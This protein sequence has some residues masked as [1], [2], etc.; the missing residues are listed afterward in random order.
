MYFQDIDLGDGYRILF[1]HTQEV[2]VVIPVEMKGKVCGLC[3]NFDGNKTND[4][5]LGYYASADGPKM[6][7]PAQVI[8]PGHPSMEGHF[9]D[10]V[11]TCICACLQK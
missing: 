6:T 10:D 1:D 11:G 5:Q 3:G 4:M 7:C 2:K 8:D 9:M